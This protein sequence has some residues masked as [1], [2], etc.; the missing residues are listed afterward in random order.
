MRR[1]PPF[2]NLREIPQSDD[3]LKKPSGFSFFSLYTTK[4]ARFEQETRSQ[5]PK[6][7]GEV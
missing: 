5:L 1:D 3:L 2:S 7:E 4:T 6:C